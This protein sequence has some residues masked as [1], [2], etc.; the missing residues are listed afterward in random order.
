[1]DNCIIEAL[2]I[3][4]FIIYKTIFYINESI[5]IVIILERDKKNI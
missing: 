2:N 3:I 4:I 1:M 5:N